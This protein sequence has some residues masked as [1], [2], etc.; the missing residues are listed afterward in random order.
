MP[1]SNHAAT[2]ADRMV[3]D[4]ISEMLTRRGATDVAINGDA[5]L[6]ADLQLESLELAELSAALEDALGTDPY[7]EGLIPETVDD[8]I[9]FYRV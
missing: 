9:G 2:T 4:L 6:M 1:N 7:T 3:Y 5:R 8:L